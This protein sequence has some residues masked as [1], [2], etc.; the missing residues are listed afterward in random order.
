ML[1][2]HMGIGYFSIY[3]SL[4]KFIVGNFHV[5]KFRVKIYS[6]SWVA[7]EKILTVNNYLVEVLPLVSLR[8]TYKILCK[9]FIQARTHG[10]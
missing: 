1:Q 5:K 10:L 7:D 3:R 8:I 4:G 2:R 6:S 9:H